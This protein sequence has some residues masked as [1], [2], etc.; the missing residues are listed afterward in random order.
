MAAR[1]FQASRII[2]SE[3][4]EHRRLQK[5]GDIDVVP[6]DLDGLWEDD[7]ECMILRLKISKDLFHQAAIDLGCDPAKA[8]S[9]I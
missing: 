2:A 8:I 4:M 5:H 9:R 1:I 3:S 7:R 6:A